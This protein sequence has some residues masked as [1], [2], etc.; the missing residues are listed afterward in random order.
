MRIVGICKMMSTMALAHRDAVVVGVP[1]H[2]VLDL[3]PALERLVNDHL[4]GVRER[5]LGQL[6]QLPVA[7]CEAGAETA[8]GVG[9][10]H[11]HG[12]AQLAGGLQGVRDVGHDQGGR[13]L[14]PDLR[15]PVRK[16]LAVLG[17]D[18][19]TNR[20]AWKINQKLFF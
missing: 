4:A 12:V 14:L 5:G 17:V 19:R 11:Q 8:Q 2:L 15:D 10:P 3:L 20:S 16:Q 6:R 9:R 7:V 13:H 18:D 1:D